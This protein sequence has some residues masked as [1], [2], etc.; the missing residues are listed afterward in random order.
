MARR[1]WIVIYPDALEPRALK[2]SQDSFPVGIAGWRCWGDGCVAGGGNTDALDCLLAVSRGRPQ[3]DEHAAGHGIDFSHQPDLVA[4]FIRI[5]LVD[6]NRIDPQD[7]VDEVVS[8]MRQCRMEVRTHGKATS[9]V[10]RNRQG[11]FLR[12]PDVRQRFV[13]VAPLGAQQ[14]A[15]KKLR[16]DGERATSVR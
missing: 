16:F 14:G 10:E 12:A 15:V 6:A 2:Q 1:G 9:V 5:A 4:L 7:A 3:P 13:R 11:L 8:Q